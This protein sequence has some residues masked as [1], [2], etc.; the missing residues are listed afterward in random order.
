V[1]SFPYFNGTG[2]VYV[3]VRQS[4]TLWARASLFRRFTDTNVNETGTAK[5][6]KTRY[7]TSG[8]CYSVGVPVDDDDGIDDAKCKMYINRERNR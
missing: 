2:S 4:D 5:I 1:A 8:Y 7:K 3:C 6:W